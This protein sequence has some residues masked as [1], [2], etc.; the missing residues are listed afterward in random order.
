[1]LT[2]AFTAVLHQLILMARDPLIYLA[3]NE[4]SAGFNADEV[5]AIRIAKA[6]AYLNVYKLDEAL[7]LAIKNRQQL[8][9]MQLSDCATLNLNVIINIYAKLGDIPAMKSYIEEA[10]NLISKD[11]PSELALMIDCARLNSGHGNPAAAREALDTIAAAIDKVEHPY[12]RVSVLRCLA[13]AHSQNRRHDL[14]LTYFSA[15]YDVASQNQ[16]SIQTLDIAIE[17]ILVCA[18]LKKFEMAERFYNVAGGLI[19]QLRLPVYRVGLYFNYGILRTIQEDFRASVL[20]YQQSL[21]ALSEIPVKLPHTKFKIYNNLAN[22]L[23]YLNEAE[24]A[25]RYQLEAEKLIADNGSPEMKTDL[26][27]NIALT[28]IA[29]KKWEEAISRLKEAVRFYKKHG[30]SEKLIRTT[31][32]IGYF[33]QEKQD[34]LRGFAVLSQL[35]QLNQEYIQELQ[36]SLSKTDEHKLLEIMA[37]SKTLRDK[38]N[39]L[40]GEVTRRQAARFTG[41]S[42]AAKRVT[43]SAVL[44]SMHLEANVLIQG[45]SGTGKEVLAQMIHYSSE[46]KNQAFVSVNCAAISTSLFE[47]E[48]FGSAAGPLTGMAEERVGCI[49]RAGEGTLFLDEISE[50]PPQF[51]QK[52]L[53][54]LDAKSYTPV[55]KSKALDVRCRI[56]SSTNQDPLELL[57]QNKFRMDL[58]HRLNTL[59]ITVPPLRDRME[60]I[61]LLVEHFARDFA[62]ETSKR[63]PQIKDSFYERLAGYQFPGNVRELKNIIE[64]IFILYYVP[65]WTADILDKIDA[66]KRNKHLS[67][68]LLE[69]NIKEL[70]KQRILE[71]LRKTNGKQKTAAKLL[72]MTESTLCRKIKRYGIK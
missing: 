58:L 11:S 14:A 47:I 41:N 16:I 46:K 49:E 10:A 32:T 43:D 33:Y 72:N 18:H 22:T 56:I 4:E 67:D 54:V 70:D 38:Y 50:M 51:Q 52:L 25:L 30:K 12:C 20:F 15:A 3:I 6:Y 27:S 39:N 35:D 9:E 57:S 13:I 2:D 19:D 34:Y 66:F 17:M 64:R 59:E 26:S 40:L 44:A 5:L 61:P 31:R 8:A 42:K 1:M 48:F 7:E 71:A 53:S 62:R 69:H 37:D 21:K 55:G 45:E 68:S 63:L 60:D 28:F 23:N 29:L 36:E 24:Q 65:V